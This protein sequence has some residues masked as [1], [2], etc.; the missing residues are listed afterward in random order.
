[1]ASLWLSKRPAHYQPAVT[2]QP[3]GHAHWMHVPKTGSSFTFAVAQWG[4]DINVT[5]QQDLEI[6][7]NA[8]FGSTSRGRSPHEVISTRCNGSFNLGG[9]IMWGHNPITPEHRRNLGAMLFTM[10]REPARRT[11]SAF[12]DGL[13]MCPELV[14]RHNCSHHTDP[15]YTAYRQDT[16]SVPLDCSRKKLVLAYAACVRSCGARMLTGHTCGRG[17][18]RRWGRSMIPIIGQGIPTKLAAELATARSKHDP[19]GLSDESLD[20]LITAYGRLDNQTGEGQSTSAGMALADFASVLNDVRKGVPFVGVTD[21]WRR[22]IC[23]FVG[24]YRRRFGGA[25]TYNIAALMTNS[26]P[27]KVPKCEAAALVALRNESWYD[28]AEQELYEAARENLEKVHKQLR[29]NQQYED[30]LASS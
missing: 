6:V 18:I 4:C 12:S 22:S 28:A 5:S 16:C 17:I 11:A 10:L 7:A 29:G 21:D 27:N 14:D 25:G 15:M 23:A 30:C 2:P 26:R 24:R 9:K 13:F 8:T 20:L 3:P 1:M 19:T